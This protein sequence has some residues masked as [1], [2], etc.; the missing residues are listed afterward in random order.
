MNVRTNGTAVLRRDKKVQQDLVRDAGLRAVRQAAGSNLEE[1]EP[2]LRNES[3]PVVVK[4]VE[5]AGSDGVQLCHTYDE[6]RQHFL[7]LSNARNQCGGINSSVLCQEFLR[8]KEYVVDQV[9]RNGVHKTTMVWVYDKRPANG[10]AFVYF[11]CV[12]VDSQS[13]EAQL[14]IPYVRSVLD[15]LGVKNGPSHGEVMMTPSGPCLVEMN[16][17]AHGGDGNWM[18][19]VRALTGYSQV[20]ASVDAYLDEKRFGELPDRPPSPFR[21]AGQEVIL[22]SYSRGTVNSTPGFDAI[23]R[24]ESFLYLETSVEIGSKVERTTDLFTCIGSAILVHPDADAV[25]RDIRRIRE[26][27][28]NDELFVYEA[29]GGRVGGG[30]LF[31]SPSVLN[32]LSFSSDLDA[33]AEKGDLSP[34]AAAPP[35][36]ASAH[37]RVISSDRMDIFW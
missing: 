3:Y 4:P 20:D 21:A 5:S 9:S 19:L 32:Q 30:E 37:R 18:P 13:P 8:G 17:R 25:E 31:R 1:V 28:E 26:M 6:A 11:G 7:R 16:V 24:L 35:A 36:A 15:A 12:P 33:V 23:R 2:F 29:G 14:I 10:A 22:V 34:S 27:E